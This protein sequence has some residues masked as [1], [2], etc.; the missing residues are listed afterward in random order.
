[1][2]DKFIGNSTCATFLKNNNKKKTP[3]GAKE[4][5]FAAVY[6]SSFPNFLL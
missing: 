1:L 5:I 4:F 2:N 6:V 3:E